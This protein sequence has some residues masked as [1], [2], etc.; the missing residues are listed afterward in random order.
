MRILRHTLLLT[1]VTLLAFPAK[2]QTV[3]VDDPIAAMLD[4]LSN[5]KV[6]EYAFQKPAFPKNNKYHFEAKNLLAL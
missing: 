1:L 2:S 4:S 3:M 5:M 6:L